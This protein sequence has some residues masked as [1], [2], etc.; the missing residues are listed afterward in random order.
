MVE[1]V[2]DTNIQIDPSIRFKDRE[3]CMYRGLLIYLNESVGEYL[4][5]CASPFSPLFFFT[6]GGSFS[7]FHAS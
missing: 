4:T 7:C 6:F 2:N 5:V 3:D 1:K